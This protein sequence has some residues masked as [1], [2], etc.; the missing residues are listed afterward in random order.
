[1]AAMKTDVYEAQ[2]ASEDLGDQGDL[3][4]TNWS[5]REMGKGKKRMK[6]EEERRP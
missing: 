3:S 6:I 5:G 4:S 1:M 2:M